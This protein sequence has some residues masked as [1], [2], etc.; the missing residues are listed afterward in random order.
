MTKIQFF[1]W[2]TIVVYIFYIKSID[3]VCCHQYENTFGDN[4]FFINRGKQYH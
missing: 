1:F 2:A 3:L 4:L